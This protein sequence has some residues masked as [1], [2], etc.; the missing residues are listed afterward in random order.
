MYLV[1]L[2]V[3]IDN[4]GADYEK[5]DPLRTPNRSTG[6][7]VDVECQYTNILVNTTK[8]TFKEA[9]ETQHDRGNECWISCLMTTTETPC[10]PQISP[11]MLFPEP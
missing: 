2:I 11:E 3:S 10:Y 1:S 4:H 5:I 9:I 6:E 8:S 7:K